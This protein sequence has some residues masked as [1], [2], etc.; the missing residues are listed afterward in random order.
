MNR[1]CVPLRGN[2]PGRAGE[3]CDGKIKYPWLSGVC[4]PFVNASFAS[5]RSREG[6]VRRISTTAAATAAAVRQQRPMPTIV[7]VAH[8]DVNLSRVLGVGGFGKVYRAKDISEDP[9]MECAAKQVTSMPEAELKKEV[10]LMRQVG[11]HPSIISF[12]HFEQVAA[13]HETPEVRLRLGPPLP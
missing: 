4:L 8:F 13:D 6:R 12:R 5:A 7:R 10:E 1:E 2:T 9:P 11:D 3:A